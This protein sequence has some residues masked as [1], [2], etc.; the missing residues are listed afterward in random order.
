MTMYSV[1]QNNMQVVN[2]TKQLCAILL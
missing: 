1:M 2:K